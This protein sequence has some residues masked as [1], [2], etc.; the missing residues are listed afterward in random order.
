MNQGQEDRIEQAYW[1]FD[2]AHKG[3]GEHKE[4]PM[5]ERDAFKRV[6]RNLL[7][8]E[9]KGKQPELDVV[10]R[11]YPESNGK[12]NWTALLV[13]V[14]PIEGLVGSGGGIVIEHSGH[15][16]NRVAYEA[17]RARYLLGRRDDEPCILDYGTDVKT[18]EEWV[19]GKAEL[20]N[21]VADEQ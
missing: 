15:Y 19:K 16:W 7:S 12:T 6:V 11:A 2:A 9:Q 14:D 10:I 1:E 3:L 20:L 18:P 21:G 13:R 4:M 17:E 8:A 5:S